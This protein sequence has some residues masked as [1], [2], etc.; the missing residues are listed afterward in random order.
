MGGASSL[1]F[2]ETEPQ[3]RNQNLG[4]LDKDLGILVSASPQSWPGGLAP[5][6]KLSHTDDQ[7]RALE[8]AYFPWGSPSAF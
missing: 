5:E 1:I 3:G 4:L 2:G 6:P 8:L 7:V